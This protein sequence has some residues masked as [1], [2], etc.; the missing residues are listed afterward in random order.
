MNFPRG[1]LKKST[2]LSNYHCLSYWKKNSQ[3]SDSRFMSLLGNSSGLTV[4]LKGMNRYGDGADLSS[5]HSHPF[6]SRFTLF[7]PG[8][9]RGRGWRQGLWV[10]HSTSALQV[11]DMSWTTLGRVFLHHERKSTAWYLSPNTKKLFMQKKGFSTRKAFND[12][13]FIFSNS[14]SQ[15]V[16]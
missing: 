3:I 13:A 10:L 5:T 4:A 2:D 7:S 15:E 1:V 11:T 9:G 12:H 6:S 16:K 14:H 8:P